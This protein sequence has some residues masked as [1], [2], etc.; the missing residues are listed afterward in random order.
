MRQ[1]NS[2]E[3]QKRNAK[4]LQYINSVCLKLSKVKNLENQLNPNG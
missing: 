2:F 3:S 1:R 4:T